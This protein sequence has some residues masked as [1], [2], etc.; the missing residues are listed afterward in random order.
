MS[1]KIELL[2]P[3]GNLEKLKFAI[4]YG[5]DA[6]Y[7]GGNKYSLRANAKNF[8]L[9]DMKKGVAYAHQKNAKVYVAINIVFHDEN[10]IGLEE[11]LKELEKI[12]VDAIIFS[13]PLVID[14][15][16]KLN[17]KME[18]HLSTQAS[19]MN[20]DAFTYFKN[21]GVSRIVLAREC[22]KNDIKNIIKTTSLEVECFIH[23]AMCTNLSGRCVLSNYFTNRDANRGGCCQV[24]RFNFNLYDNDKNKLSS[25][26]NFSIAPKDLS[27]V[28]HLEEMIDIGVSSF[29]LE[30]RMRSI[31]YIATIVSVYRK[32]IDMYVNKRIDNAYIMKATKI[33]YRC[34]NRDVAPQFFDKM[35][36][37]NEQYYK[38][39][40]EDSNQD[41]LGV[42]LGYDEEEKKV[43]VEQ[44][45]FFKVGD[46]VNVFA[47]NMEDY[48]FTINTITDDE[49]NN[50]DAA[51]HPR[52]I[53]KVN[54]DKRIPKN[55]IMRVNFLDW[56]KV[57][58]V[59][60]L[61]PGLK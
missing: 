48:S 31:Y 27:L 49:G 23:G 7:L 61:Y 16:K 20:K 29:K 51:R 37:K 28:N 3:A 4:D 44:R 47:P 25:E 52:Q 17:L 12:K 2:A 9:D 53:I 32:L 55:A 14:V 46:K 45:N 42:I 59:V 24:C 40:K 11:Y 60:I 8:S 35:P 1:K 56:Q 30:G 58:F 10:V 57:L 22:N 18:L 54:C 50:L 33:L 43:I 19:V 5:A 39:R 36:G 34:A 41:F 13:D 21:K 38:K 15:A 6:V 26:D